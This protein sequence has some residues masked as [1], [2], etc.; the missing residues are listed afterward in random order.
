MSERG[1]HSC[2]GAGG[3]RVRASSEPGQH[4]RWLHDIWTRTWAWPWGDAES[5]YPAEIVVPL[6]GGQGNAT[7]R[8]VGTATKNFAPS[9]SLF[10]NNL[11]LRS[12]LEKRNIGLGQQ[13]N[14]FSPY[15]LFSSS[16][17]SPTSPRLLCGT[18]TSLCT[19]SLCPPEGK[20][21]WWKGMG[22]AGSG[23]CAGLAAG[24][25]HQYLRPRCLPAAGRK[26]AHVCWDVPMSVRGCFCGCL[27]HPAW[28]PASPLCVPLS[29][30]A[31]P[32]LLLVRTEAASGFPSTTLLRPAYCSLSLSGS[33]CVCFVSGSPVLP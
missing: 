31:H 5:K 24:P 22:D 6:V 23:A 13:A 3:K 25:L 11:K 4:S 17:S 10:L 28:L 20:V 8:S 7:R 2:W 30:K 14:H 1:C 19:G 12:Y 26:A 27:R 16:C 33:L 15:V 21:G 29:W 18:P 9:H 32:T